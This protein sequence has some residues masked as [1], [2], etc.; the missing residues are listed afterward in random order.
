[1]RVITLMVV[2]LLCSVAV[3]DE[4]LEWR[5]VGPA[6]RQVAEEEPLTFSIVGPC[7]CREGGECTCGLDCRCKTVAQSK[8]V[9][10]AYKDFNLICPGCVQ[11]SDDA[12]ELP[13]QL[14]WKPAPAWVR[15][16]PT[17]HWQGVD[18]GWYQYQ[19]GRAAD[20][21]NGFRR[22]WEAT[23]TATVQRAEGRRQ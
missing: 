18:G 13:V 15:S 5:I 10:F 14:Q 8:P 6:S 17:L 1:M 7:R 9:A 20:D 12:E 2:G 19:W 16:Y 4:P 21:V 11:L 3:A 22:M 23:Q